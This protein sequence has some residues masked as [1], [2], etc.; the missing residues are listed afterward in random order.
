MKINQFNYG[1]I[2]KPLITNG[3]GYFI[4]IALG[5]F[6][7]MKLVFLVI[8]IIY[9]ITFRGEHEPKAY[10]GDENDIVF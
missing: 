3:L 6:L 4:A 5:V 1:V 10:H 9:M 2:N 7:F 8:E